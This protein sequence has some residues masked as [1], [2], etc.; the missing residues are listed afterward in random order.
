MPMPCG[1]PWSIAP[2]AGCVY[3]KLRDHPFHARRWG[4]TRVILPCKHLGKYLDNVTC[5]PCSKKGKVQLKV[6]E[7][8]IHERCTSSTKIAE[9]RG[10]CKGCEDKQEP[11]RITVNNGAGGIGD[12]ILGLR[13]VVGLKQQ[14]PEVKIVYKVGERA[15][16]FVMLFQGPDVLVPY[17]DDDMGRRELEN[18]D[19]QLN[20][21]YLVGGSESR[22]SRYC[23]N[24]GVKQ[25]GPLVL[26]DR[27]GVLEAGKEYRDYVVLSTFSMGRNREYPHVVAL[28]KK[29]LE[30]GHR[31]LVLNHES[32][33]LAEFSGL[34]VA[35][36]D[37]KKLAGILLNAACVIGVDSGMAHLAGAL[38][39]PTLVLCRVTRGDVIFDAYPSCQVIQ[40]SELSTEQVVEKVGATVLRSLVKDRTLVSSDR[41]AVIRDCVLATNHLPGDAAEVGVYR[42]GTA[43]LISYFARDT[44][45]HLFD[46]FEGIPNDDNVE[47][48]YHKAGDFACPIEDVRAYLDAFGIVFHQG[49]FP[50][51]APESTT[52]RF[53][54]LDGDTYQTT[55]DA[56]A[57]FVPR[58]IPGGIIT[59]DDYE[60]EH[61]PGV[62]QAIEEAG[63]VVETPAATQC[64][65]RVSL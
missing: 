19:R 33:R 9:V 54:H 11:E 27:A 29:L 47:G 55:Q 53:V 23:H 25:P 32:E 21:G 22:L 2:V 62:K 40:Y 30:A 50:Y 20:R 28:E 36:A 6:F 7:C 63:L 15:I 42:G 46:T 61:C 24:I 1:H 13:A 65:Y 31:V 12:G 10:C 26:S 56:I 64:I 16:P 35:T 5:E 44:T 52:F 57:Y 49:V 39:V 34:T 41:L 38:G 48:G 58:M 59:F 4:D 43:K 18:D 60:W 45:L 3:C 8:A 14:H 17:D 51:T 37:A